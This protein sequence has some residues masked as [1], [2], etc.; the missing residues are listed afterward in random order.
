MNIAKRQDLFRQVSHDSF[1][2]GLCYLQASPS[3]YPE[4][5]VGR[6]TDQS[7]NHGLGDKKDQGFLG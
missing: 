1:E 4:S 6:E 2:L 3:G 5:D 7:C